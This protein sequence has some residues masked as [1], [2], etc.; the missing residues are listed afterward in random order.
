MQVQE[1]DGNQLS[2]LA[3]LLKK[4]YRGQTVLVVGHSNT[5][6]A[7]AN[8]IVGSQ[9]L[10]EFDEDDYGNLLVVTVKKGG[11]AQVQRKQY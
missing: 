1:Y 11:G 9:Q 7:L 2:A 8:M 3:E 4:E 10:T 5:T 6:P